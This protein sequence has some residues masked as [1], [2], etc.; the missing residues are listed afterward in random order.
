M[1]ASLNN[2]SASAKTVLVTGGSTGIGAE[3]IKTFLAR[4]EAH[5]YTLSRTAIKVEESFGK[6]ANR[7]TC[8]QL[9]LAKPLPP[10][11]EILPPDRPLDILIHN[12]GSLS[13]APFAQTTRAQWE[14]TFAV[15]VFG[16]VEL[17]QRLLPNLGFAERPHIVTIGSMGGYQGASKFAGLSAYSASKGALATLSQC[18]AVELAAQQIR[19]NCLCLGATNTE[20]LRKAF[21]GYTAPVSAAQMGE[22]I[23]DFAL[24]AA[25]VMNGQIIPVTGGDPG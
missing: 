4:T 1:A 7:V 8:V 3:V 20:M 12:A 16:I 22:F 15:N 2:P 10:N 9:D 13:P 25:T 24:H 18:L 5:V 11:L 19:V 6:F 17:T 14:H 23:V 21:P